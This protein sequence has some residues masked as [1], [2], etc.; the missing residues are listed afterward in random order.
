MATFVNNLR[1]TEITTGDESGTWGTTTNSNWDFATDA[2]GYGVKNMAG[3][4]DQ[5]FTMADGTVDTLRSMYL[6]I[7][8]TVAPLTA[9]RTLTIAPNTVSKVWII[10]NNAAGS[11]SIIIKQGSGATV[12]IATGTKAMVY[13]DGLG[14]G[15]AVFVAGPTVSLTSGVT[16]ILPVANGGT[17]LAAGTSGGVLAYTGSGT[18]ASSAA[19]T[20]YGVVYG[21]GAGAV[22]V[23]TAAGTTGQVL[24]ATTSGAPSWAA[25]AAGGITYT[26]TKT[27]NYTAVANDGVLTNTTAGAFTVTLPA[28]PANGDQVIVADAGGT[29]GTNNLTV[30]RNGNNIADVAQDLVCDIAGASVQFVYNTSGTATWEVYAQIGGNGGTAV[31]LDGVQTLTNKTLTAPTIA[32]ANLTTAL[33]LAGAAGTSGQVLTSAGSGLPTWAAAGATVVLSTRTSNTIL[34]SGDNSTLVDITSGTFSQTFTAAATLGS[35]WFCYIRNSGTG[36]ITLDPNAS[37]LIDG[38]STYIMYGGETRL[39]QCTGTAFTSVVL[40]PFYRAFTASGTFTKPPGYS[41]FSGLIWSGGSSAGKRTNPT[42]ASGG[43]GGGSG[44]FILPSASFAATETITIGAG[45]L[46]RTASDTV[47]IAG[48]TSSIGALV[49]A[50][51]VN[52]GSTSGGS[53]V[54]GLTGNGGVTSGYEGA[55]PS[56]DAKISGSIWGGAA[57]GTSDTSVIGVAI[58]GGAAGGFIDSTNALIAPGVSRFGGNGG[59]ASVA[60]SGVAGTAPGGG[61]GATRTGTTSGAGARGEVRI[62]GIA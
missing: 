62:W 48:G 8:S 51:G 59:A 20:Q 61:G 42:V 34:A 2:F 3:D 54:Q 52:S 27:G 49:F 18:L 55:A 60:G 17:N 19:L 31:T 43:G 50:Y 26:V 29:W 4:A 36:D 16:G 40:S 1:L 41:C 45:G 25:P 22:P 57:S 32:S 13:T 46:G 38:L 5:T 30:G 33:T 24:T 39:V 35:G 28:T 6:K 15:G 12:T 9:T 56:T 14:S 37:E 21:G 47:G 44:D 11:Q 53:I 7:T 10:E 58:Y 23:A